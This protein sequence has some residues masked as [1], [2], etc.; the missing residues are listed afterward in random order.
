MASGAAYPVG[1]SQYG[2]SDNGWQRYWS[3][4]EATHVISPSRVSFRYRRSTA[5]LPPSTRAFRLLDNWM[6]APQTRF[7]MEGCLVPVELP[8]A[9][10]CRRKTACGNSQSNAGTANLKLWRT[11]RRRRNRFDKLPPSWVQCRRPSHRNQPARAA[12]ARSLACRV[13]ASPRS[14][15]HGRTVLHTR[16]RRDRHRWFCTP[17]QQRGKT[18]FARPFCSPRTLPITRRQV[19]NQ[20]KPI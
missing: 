11:H 17:Q 10:S 5:T 14:F 12:P 15:F 2:T 9:N 4:A 6:A 20:G 1:G 8:A 18:A 16:G 7:L 19:G 3:P 13:M